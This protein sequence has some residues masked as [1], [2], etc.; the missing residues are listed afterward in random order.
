MPQPTIVDIPTTEQAQMR[1]E[2]RRARYGYL[3]A[4]QILGRV[5][6]LLIKEKVVMV[7]PEGGTDDGRG[8]RKMSTL[9]E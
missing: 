3:L 6:Y 1:A 9:A 2:L 8:S 4:V 7:E 5:S